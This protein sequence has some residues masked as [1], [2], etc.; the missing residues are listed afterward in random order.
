MEGLHKPSSEYPFHQAIYEVRPDIKA[1]V[2]AHPSALVSFSIVRQVPDTSVIP[3]ANHVCG[4]VGYSKYEMPGSEELGKSISG[5]FK[6]GFDCVLMENHGTVVG[7][8]HLSD[9]FEKFETLEFCARTI[10]EGSSIGTVKPLN[11]EQID[12]FNHEQHILSELKDHKYGIREKELRGELCDIIKR[13]YRQRLIIST[14]GTFSARVD[15]DSFL[16]TPYGKDRYQLERENLVLIEGQSRE[17][18]KIPS[19]SVRLHM[20]I[21]KEFPDIHCVL[22]AQSPFA[23]AY[24]ITGK[25][26]DT[27]TIPES[28][29]LLREIPIVPY[30]DQF[31]EGSNIIGHLKEKKPIMLIENDT[32]LVT[33]KSILETFDTLEVA[34]FSARSLTQSR[35]L[36]TMV[37]IEEKEIEDIKKKFLSD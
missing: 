20:N 3:Q 14:Y 18:G 35:S 9:A 17:E 34:E 33:G 32:I 11:D 29:I 7:G 21:Y 23:T 2:H 16:I 19:R 31:G 6:K 26:F 37:P 15:K 10:M 8:K 1:I 5:S 28:Y 25:T 30:G 24:A 27:R 12:L 36:G 4:K 13:A 22:T